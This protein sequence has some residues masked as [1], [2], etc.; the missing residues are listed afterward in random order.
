MMFVD[1]SAYRKISPHQYWANERPVGLIPLRGCRQ[2][3]YEKYNRSFGHHYTLATGTG[4]AIEVFERWARRT[5][6][7][8]DRSDARL[9]AARDKLAEKHGLYARNS[10]MALNDALLL[11]G[12]W[13]WIDGEPEHYDYEALQREIAEEQEQLSNWR[14]C[15]VCG[16]SQT[17]RPAWE[18][19]AHI[20]AT[21][22]GGYC[23]DKKSL[24]VKYHTCGRRRCAKIMQQALATK[25]L[26]GLKTTEL[27][28]II[29]RAMPHD[30]V[31][32][33]IAF[34]TCYM[35][36]VTRHRWPHTLRRLPRWEPRAL[37]QAISK[38]Q[39]KWI[40]RVRDYATPCSTR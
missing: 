13:V 32:A 26:V 29:W 18:M 21:Y 2:T 23:P 4:W 8:C 9:K 28:Q 33:H 16:S 37:M 24:I 35:L 6:L 7:T 38:T 30:P 17:D 19:A 11:T 39:R 1:Q 10:R 40:E 3:L 5:R 22:L 25:G 15:L 34:L 20:E 31:R 36:Y 12:H 14:L 27:A